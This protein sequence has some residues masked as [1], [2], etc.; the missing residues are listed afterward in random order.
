MFQY[1]IASAAS[2]APDFSNGLFITSANLGTTVAT[3][4]CGLIISS[5]GTQY[6]VF[7]GLLFLALGTIPILLR[8]CMYNPIKQLSNGVYLRKT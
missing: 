8:V 7:G 4:V 6:V 5:L 2:E 3:T 1:W